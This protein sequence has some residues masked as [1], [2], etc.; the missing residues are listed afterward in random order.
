MKTIE[1]EYCENITNKYLNH[2]LA[3]PFLQPVDEVRDGAVGYHDI[4]K[5]PMDLTTLHNNLKA[6]KYT[7]SEEWKTDFL[8]IWA[9]AI[10]YNKKQKNMVFHIAS[11]LQQEAKQDTD[12]IPKTS[13]DIWFLKLR[14]AALKVEEELGKGSHSS[15]KSRR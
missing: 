7:K 14:Q 5:H 13:N 3:I 2:D 1:R 8:R 6:N 10:E 4:I 9:N 12:I 11:I 15:S